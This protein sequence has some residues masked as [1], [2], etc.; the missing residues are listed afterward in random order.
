[1]SG[2]YFGVKAIVAA[3]T[4][5]V[6]GAFKSLL[7][8]VPGFSGV[9]GAASAGINMGAKVVQA[10]IAAGEGVAGGNPLAFVGAVG[11]MAGNLGVDF[12]R[13]MPAGE[14]VQYA[15]K[16]GQAIGG[17]IDGVVRGDIGAALDGL[18]GLSGTLGRMGSF[19]QSIADGIDLARRGAS[20]VEQV[21]SA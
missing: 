15:I 2:A 21:G 11:G 8:A 6:L 18:G 1:I 10:G 7:S 12:G 9:F 3:A 4:G 17:V 20:T 13:F 14:A 5:D 19:G 16:E